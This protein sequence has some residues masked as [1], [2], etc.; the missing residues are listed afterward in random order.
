MRA[1][2]LLAGCLGMALGL[3]ACGSRVDMAA[4]EANVRE[5]IT[6]YFAAAESQDWDAAADVVSSDYV[7]VTH[8]GAAM[9]LAGIRQFFA[10]HITDHTIAIRNITVTVSGDG[11]M[12]WATFDEDT[13]YNFDGAP[14]DEHALFTAVLENGSD[15][16][17]LMHVQRTIEVAM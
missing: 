2:L 11:S 5:V 4:E 9:D 12:A 6:D 16:W 10:D 1:N 15:G 8:M 3:N 17:K 14:M 13:Q 7:I